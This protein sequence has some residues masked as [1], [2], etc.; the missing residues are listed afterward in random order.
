MNWMLLRRMLTW[1]VTTTLLAVA[2]VALVIVWTA[3]QR[4]W[5]IDS[6]GVNLTLDVAMTAAGRWLAT[7]ALGGLMLLCL[8]TLAVEFSSLRRLDLTD[9]GT[10][11]SPEHAISTGGAAFTY[12]ARGRQAPAIL[13]AVDGAGYQSTVL[14]DSDAR[15]MEGS[16]PPAPAPS[17]RDSTQT[18]AARP[19]I[20]TPPMRRM[21]EMRMETGL[22]GGDRMHSTVP[23][24]TGDR[25]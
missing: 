17:A 22:D 11:P 7:T 1:T 12:T 2:A 24:Q 14:G 5:F 16:M 3:N 6:A 25:R 4:E 21:M 19:R 13:T 9:S 23:L 10:L 8:A 15:R 18:M 20:A